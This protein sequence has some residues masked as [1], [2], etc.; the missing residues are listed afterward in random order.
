MYFLA[1]KIPCRGSSLGQRILTGLQALNAV[2]LAVGFP[3][4]NG[5]ATGIGD[6]Q[7][8]TGQLTAIRH[9]CFGDFDLGKVVFHLHALNIP[10]GAN[11]KGDAFGADIALLGGGHRLG[12][13]VRAHRDALHIV[14][15]AVRDPFSNRLAVCVSNFQLCT[16]D[17]LAGSNIDLETCTFV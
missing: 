3:L 6:F 4:G 11:L 9:V 12:Q 1:E 14:R 15:C 13:G 7:L 10:G 2:W 5:A 8:C 16:A 17:F